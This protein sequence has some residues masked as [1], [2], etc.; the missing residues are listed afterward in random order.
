MSILSSY[1]FSVCLPVVRSGLRGRIHS[2]VTAKSLRC[3]L[4]AQAT[5]TSLRGSALKLAHDSLYSS[6]LRAHGKFHTDRS[7]DY[8]VVVHLGPF[9]FQIR[10]KLRG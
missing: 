9:H 7:A 1:L 10:S 6:T 8:V 3:T 4:L 5:W 2:W